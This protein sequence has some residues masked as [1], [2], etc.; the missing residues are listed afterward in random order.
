[1]IGLITNLHTDPSC[2]K[3]YDV[4]NSVLADKST[5]TQSGTNWTYSHT[6][7]GALAIF[8]PNRVELMKLGR[9]VVIVYTAT[10][11]LSVEVE[12]STTLASGTTPSGAT[13]KAAKINDSGDARSIYCRG[14]GSVTLKAMAVYEADAWPTVQQLLPKFPWFTGDTMPRQNN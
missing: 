13:W 8:P 6:G 2:L 4:W 5:V 11:G 7:S 12:N 10:N 9:V 3:S 14:E 1:M